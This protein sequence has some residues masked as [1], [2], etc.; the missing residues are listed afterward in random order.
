MMH[1]L[2]A[3]FSREWFVWDFVQNNIGTRTAP[4][5]GEFQVAV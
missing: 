5:F 1:V 4:S 2:K 3:F